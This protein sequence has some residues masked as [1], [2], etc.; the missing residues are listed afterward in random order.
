MWFKWHLENVPERCGRQKFM[1]WICFWPSMVCRFLIFCYRCSWG[2]S[3]WYLTL[4]VLRSKTQNIDFTCLESS[5]GSGQPSDCG[6]KLCS[7][8]MEVV[9]GST[10]WCLHLQIVQ[11]F[12]KHLTLRVWRSH[13]KTWSILFFCVVCLKVVGGFPVICDWTLTDI[14]PPW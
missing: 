11:W 13:G 2:P 10:A 4:W 1:L 12:C 8:V 5:K 9:P 3:G 7:I 6:S 14:D